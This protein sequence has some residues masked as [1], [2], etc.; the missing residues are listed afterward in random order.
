MMRSAIFV[1]LAC[2]VAAEQCETGNCDG[3]D[4]GTNLLQVHADTSRNLQPSCDGSPS[5][6]TV[7]FP[8]AWLPTT[9]S[10]QIEAVTQV[11]EAAMA[12]HTCTVMF[13]YSHNNDLARSNLE[14]A[15]PDSTCMWSGFADLTSPGSPLWPLFGLIIPG[16]GALQSQPSTVANVGGI[17]AGFGLHASLVPATSCASTPSFAQTQ[18]RVEKK[19]NAKLLTIATAEA[20]RRCTLTGTQVS[21]TSITTPKAGVSLSQVQAAALAAETQA[22]RFSCVSLYRYAFDPSVNEAVNHEVYAD[23]N[24][25]QSVF[26]DAAYSQAFATLTSVIDAKVGYVAGP[27]AQLAQLAQTGAINLITPESSC[28]FMP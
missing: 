17:V 19:K 7:Q 24:C 14:E 8:F 13:R 22:S 3:L 9:T 20:N 27:A 23:A 26:A 5:V 10:S 21:Q 6:I 15:Y 11:I 4:D 16:Q 25:L 12:T 1:V 28:S 18:V 2:A